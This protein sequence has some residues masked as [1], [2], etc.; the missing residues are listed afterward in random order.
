VAD[1]RHVVL[2]G[3]V[4]YTTL[5]SPAE[6]AVHLGDPAWVIVDCRHELGDVDAGERAH[7]AGHIAGAQFMHM[8]RDLS[9]AKTGVNGRHPLPR[10]ADIVATFSRAGID[11]SKQVIAYDQNNGMWAAR[12]WWLLQWLGHPAAAVLDGGLDR[13]IAKGRSLTAEGPRVQPATFVAGLPTPTASAKEIVEHLHDGALTVI[14]A[15]APERY[16]GDVEPIDPVAGHIPGAVN[17]PYNANLSAQ[18]TFK[19]ALQLRAEFDALLDEAPP[20]SVV[21]QCGSGV[22]ACHNVLAMTVAGLPGS[23]LYP[24]SWSEWIAAPERPI[25]RG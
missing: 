9:G 2:T 5:I 21:H 18:G 7:R 24:G 8:D 4:P 23:R 17:R 13:W 10:I 1:Y 20:E 3:R 16:R 14:D 12:L 15:R 11:D 25:A 19:P 22:T 6:L